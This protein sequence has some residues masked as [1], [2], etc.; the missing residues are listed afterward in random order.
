M[1]L[2]HA[3]NPPSRAA[4]NLSLTIL[5]A[6]WAFNF[7]VAKIALRS[8]PALTLASFR[9][10]LAGLAM[11]LVYPICR[12]MPVFRPAQRAAGSGFSARDLWTFSYLAFFGVAVNQVCFTVGLRY[13]SVTHSAIIVGMGPIYVLVLAIL[14]RLEAATARKAIGMTVALA[15]VIVM[16]GGPHAAQRSASLLGDAITLTGSLGF[17]LYAVLGKRVAGHYDSLTMTTANFLIGALIVSPL[18]FRQAH[19][20]GPWANWRAIPA[21]AWAGLFFM[22]LFSSVL[23]YLFYFWL[24]RFL[25]VSQ[26]STFSYLLPP[27]ATLLGILFLG[28]RGSWVELLGGAL[29]LSGVYFVESARFN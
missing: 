20:L 21:S 19:A 1:Q 2:D 11:V 5:L 18:A 13:T 10:V 4:L 26:L 8:I 6:V 7:L 24:L 23:A 12:R 17:A 22:A 28:E 29:A 14:L 3:S 9:V 16:A 15:G 27:S 25:L